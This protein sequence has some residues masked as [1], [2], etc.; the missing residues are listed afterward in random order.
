MAVMAASDTA[1]FEVSATD[2]KKRKL[3]VATAT[4]V[5]AAGLVASGIPFIQ[6]WWP[7]ERA[8]AA[9]APVQVDASKLE[10]GQQ[11]TVAWRGRPVWV[12]RRTPEMLLRMQTP[13]HLQHLRDPDSAVESQQPPYARNRFRSIHDEH[14]VVIGIC[15]HLGCVPTFRPDVAPDDLGADWI[16]G[17]FCP[18]HG[19]RFDLAG[20]VFVN[21]PA[22]TNLVIPPYHYISDTLIEVGVDSS[23]V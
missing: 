22:P 10:A 21:V 14:L 7:S 4:V 18:C 11:I 17:Y 8:R 20:R 15:T 9:G 3:L 16:G 19:S 1:S 12:L 23:T 6:S 5:G 2:L 13:Q